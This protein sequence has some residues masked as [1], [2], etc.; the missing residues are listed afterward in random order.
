MTTLTD[1]IGRTYDVQPYASAAFP[2]SA[3]EHLRAVAHLF[4]LESAPP[5]RARVLELG[6][7]AGGNL[8][9]FAVR[10]PDAQVVGVDL[11][12]VQVEAGRRVIDAMG[13]RNA[14]LI[15]ASIGDLD[16]S[17]GQFDYII[18]HG[19]Y[20]WVPEEV[21]AAILRVAHELLA[22]DGVAYVSY[23]TYPGWKAKEIVRDAM[24][25]RGG[26]RATVD[27]QLAYARGMIDFLHDMAP[28]DSVLARVMQ[29][30]IQTVRHGKDFYLAHEFL[31]LCNAPCYFRD[32]LGAAR[33]QGMDY[34]GDA[35]VGSMFAANYGAHAAELLMRECNG[36]QT[37]LEQ[38]LDFLS[39]RTFRQTL[40]VH[41]ER[42]EGIRYRL[43]P[44]RIAAL[45]LAGR[46]FAQSDDGT[47]WTSVSGQGITTANPI[48]RQ[49]IERINAA[50]PSTVSVQSLVDASAGDADAAARMLAF[51]GELIAGNAV[52]FRCEPLLAANEV[53]ARP[54]VREQLRQ[55]AALHGTTPME[56][57]NEWHRSV[58]ELGAVESFLMS[59][60]DGGRDVAQLTGEVVDAIG[61]GTLV[62]SRDGQQID[63][64]QEVARSAAALTHQA[65]QWF[66]A[67][68]L[69]VPNAASTTTSTKPAKA[70][71]P[72]QVAK[73]TKTAR[74]EKGGKDEKS[75][76]AA[77]ANRGSGRKV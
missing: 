60:L 6:C 49:V 25:L 2:H 10:H 57:F 21:R 33:A 52:Q 26:D 34:L 5:E 12:A 40:L 71:K 76:K 8:I 13:L 46:Y 51:I 39:N 64:A 59:R 54:L 58:V 15:K 17:L 19:V 31:E 74:A 22:P 20:S 77:K 56:L 55:L 29:D 9:P 53:E 50:W 35:T 66:A 36:D 47:S 43:D 11:S 70:G 72:P 16:A 41:G 38:L 45:H 1:R 67:N 4:G 65:L 23:N 37:A 62:L 69:L 68:A 42:T 73:A 32:F 61:D 3:P 28:A 44:A 18:C 30:N 75:G 14:R 24:L 27:E 63:D 7:A 48:D